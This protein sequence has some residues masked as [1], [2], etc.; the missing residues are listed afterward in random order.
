MTVRRSSHSI[1]LMSPIGSF[2]KSLAS[3]DST[4]REKG[5]QSAQTY[6]SSKA[7]E[8]LTR[9]DIEKLCKGL[10]FAMWFCD[11]PK[12]QEQLAE[13]IGNL[14][15]NAVSL[16][17]FPQLL[18]A[19]WTIMAR[20]WPSVDQWRIDKYYLLMRRVLRHSLIFLERN[21]W[22]S[23]LVSKY[24]DVLNEGPLSG[25]TSISVAL[26]Y[27]LC[28][29]YLD[30]L[31]VV[32]FAGLESLQEELE[33]LEDESSEEFIEKRD[34]LRA[35]EVAAA[36]ATPVLDLISCFVQLTDKT[37]LKTLKEKCKEEVIENDKLQ[38]WR[39]IVETDN[40]SDD[41]GDD[42]EEEWNGF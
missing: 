19:F 10:Y 18:L 24:L 42:D 27:H 25:D 20:E 1:P 34:Q 23:D 4:V 9:L 21:Q 32:M 36:A 8:N 41:D 6:L 26:P 13:Q 38:Q 17:L 33:N 16:S 28:D 37:R 3:N 12:P 7:A 14:F 29:I 22:D 39:V 30:E 31:A 35:Q 15:S 5:F 11:K 40:E 2:V